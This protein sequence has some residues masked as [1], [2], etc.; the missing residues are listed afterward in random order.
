[1]NAIEKVSD[2]KDHNQ[3]SQPFLCCLENKIKK[4]DVQALVFL[5]YMK[6]EKHWLTM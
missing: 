4:K 6:K 1:M 2:A 5:V 3:P